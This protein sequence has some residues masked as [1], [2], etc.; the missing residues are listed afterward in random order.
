MPPQ[1]QGPGFA[2]ASMLPARR[3]RLVGLKWR[4]SPTWRPRHLS[5]SEP[6]HSL[7]AGR[8]G[9]WTG[10][11]PWARR[12]EGARPRLR[13]KPST[14]PGCPEPAR[15]ELHPGSAAEAEE[16]AGCKNVAIVTSRVPA[17]AQLGE[18]GGGAVSVLC[19]VCALPHREVLSQTLRE[20]LPG[21]GVPPKITAPRLPRGP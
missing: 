10:E 7:R 1:L 14:K 18:E 20:C 9:G 2:E 3:R 5:G 19:R 4:G 16:D 11:E 21:R 17:P 15:L 8:E 6:T 12:L 13:P